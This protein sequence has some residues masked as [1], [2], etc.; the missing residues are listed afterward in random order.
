M[1]NQGNMTPPEEYSKPLETVPKEMEVKELADKEINIIVLI[2]AEIYKK[3][4]INYIR[5]IIQEYKREKT[6]IEIGTEEYND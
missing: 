2:C 5:K 6:K 4:Q 1:K 3:T